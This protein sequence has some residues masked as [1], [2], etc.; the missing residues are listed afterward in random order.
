MD[1]SVRVPSD[2]KD[3]KVEKIVVSHIPGMRTEMIICFLCAQGE[4]L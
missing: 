3:T 4:H 2:E 1:L